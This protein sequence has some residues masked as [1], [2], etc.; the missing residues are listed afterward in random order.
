MTNR[1][2]GTATSVPEGG[3]LD[4]KFCNPA[5]ANQEVTITIEGDEEP[6]RT[7]TMQLDA[8]GCGTYSGFQPESSWSTFSLQHETSDFH[9]VN[10]IAGG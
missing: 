2:A 3:T 7:I 1:F 8:D 10:I 4:I 6:D 9:P 5:L